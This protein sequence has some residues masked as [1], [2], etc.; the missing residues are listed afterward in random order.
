MSISAGY[1]VVAGSLSHLVRRIL[2]GVNDVLVASAAAEI[3]FQGVAN[4]TFGWVWV[5]VE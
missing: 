1:L 2:N 4:F 3:A 5:T